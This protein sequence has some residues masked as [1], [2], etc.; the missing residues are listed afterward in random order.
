MQKKCKVLRDGTS[1]SGL[2][3]VWWLQLQ[4]FEAIHHHSI[5]ILDLR[6]QLYTVVVLGIGLRIFLDQNWSSN[7]ET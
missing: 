3:Q 7:T 2:N 5:K 1:I 4:K 6:Q